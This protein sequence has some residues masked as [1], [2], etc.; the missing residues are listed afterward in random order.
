MMAVQPTS[1]RSLVRLLADCNALLVH[2]DDDALKTRDAQ[3]AWAEFADNARDWIDLIGE[4]R[5]VDRLNAAE[6]LDAQLPR[7]SNASA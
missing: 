6:Q 5:E 3:R 2:A 7:N 1:G 4:I